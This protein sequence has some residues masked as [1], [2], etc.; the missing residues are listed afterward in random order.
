[1][2]EIARLEQNALFKGKRLFILQDDGHL[3]VYSSYGG[4]KQ[5]FLVDIGR[6]NPEPFRDSMSARLFIAILC[7][8]ALLSILFAVLII[9]RWPELDADAK[10]VLFLALGVFGFGALLCW[11]E[12][13]R[14]SYDTYA[15]HDVFTGQSIIF[16]ANIP[17]EDLFMD[18]VSK[19]QAEIRSIQ[20]RNASAAR[21]SLVEQIEE[22]GRLKAEG[23]LDDEEFARAK[24]NLI[25]ASRLPAAIGF[26]P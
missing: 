11:R 10:L 2:K 22:L 17:S 26:K 1:M 3:K 12:Y 16:L 25:E 15:F 8:F 14:Q 21:L 4:R 23:L 9:L 7:F 18:F 19:L 20:K 5:E 24:S 13:L 6:L